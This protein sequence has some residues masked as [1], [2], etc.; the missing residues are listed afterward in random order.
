MFKHKQFLPIFF[1]LMFAPATAVIQANEITFEKVWVEQTGSVIYG[2]VQVDDARLY[3][4]AED[5]T[6]R[7]IDKVTGKV[8]WTFDAGAAI[9]SNAAVGDMRVYFHTRDGVIH[10]IDKAGG[11][12]LWTF[13]TEGER[14]WDYWDYYLS[15][16]AIDDRQIYVGSGD[17]HVYGLDKRSGHLRWKVKTGNIV[18]GE[19][20]IS[21]EKVIVGGFEGRMYAIDRGTGRVLWTFKTVGT[22][23]FRNGELP[24][25][26]TVKD[27][28]VYFGGRDYNIYALLEDTGT[29]A[30]NDKTPSWIVGRPLA[31]DDDL[32]VVNSDGAGIF[33]YNN[34]NG[35]QNWA[36]T[37]SYNMFAGAEALG[38]GH[39]AIASL[40]GRIT[41]LA[42]A[43]GSQAGVYETDG[44]LATRNRFF[45]DDG[46]IDYTGV[47]SMEDLTDLY[48]R[49][50]DAMDGITGSIVVEA[51]VVYYA[52]A[53]GEIAAIRVNGIDLPTEAQP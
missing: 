1:A 7:A 6:L 16:P 10:A 45:N 19:P 32:I 39:L 51:N 15:T 29:G 22:A 38:A 33:S 23:Y 42:R 37:N 13:A 27:G 2:G 8:D 31:V 14:Q 12:E 52:T 43:D 3:V 28:I 46:Q 21:G 34:S 36:F 48:D 4:G 41:I 11:G 30:W 35:Q 47:Q 20:V 49:Q 53:G 26:A 9:A 17:H 44:S 50:L 5:G 25:A 24:G 40:D 18:H